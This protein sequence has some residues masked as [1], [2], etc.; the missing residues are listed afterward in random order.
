MNDHVAPL[1]PVTFP[2]NP[3]VGEEYLAQNNIV[4]RWDGVVWVART[5]EYPDPGL[6]QGTWQVAANVPDLTANAILNEDGWIWLAQTADYLFGETADAA[7][8][9]IGSEVIWN[10]WI[11]Q[12]VAATQQYIAINTMTL[13]I[14]DANNIASNYVLKVG[15]EVTGTLI[16]PTTTANFGHALEITDGSIQFYGTQ[17]NSGINITDAGAFI[18]PWFVS[19]PSATAGYNGGFAFGT[20]ANQDGGLYNSNGLIIRQNQTDTVLRAELNDGSQ[21]WNI[22]DQRAG[23]VFGEFLFQVPAGVVGFG[24]SWSDTNNNFIAAIYNGSTGNIIFRTENNGDA[25]TA[26][27][28]RQGSPG[29]LANL[30]LAADPVQLM[31][32]ATKNYVDSTLATIVA[33]QGT[34]EV[35]ANNPDLDPAVVNPVGGWYWIASTVDPNTPEMA[36]ATL[37]GIG[38]EMI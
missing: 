35:A 4:Y 26:M 33:F 18:G 17:G 24:L 11:I 5:A 29:V 16:W 19:R 21:S 7:I 37:P 9:G 13:N 15:D 10:G 32:A 12:W 20:I 2:P 30:Q 36:L 25:Q 8:P 28:I 23:T 31:D 34:W 27:T 1:V 38:G 3:T 6:Y 22:I 14:D